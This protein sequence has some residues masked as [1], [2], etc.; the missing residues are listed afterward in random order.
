MNDMN[1]VRHCLGL[2]QDIV[3]KLG[4][5]VARAGGDSY[6]G[7]R[8]LTTPEGQN[9]L[10]RIG[11]ILADGNNP[12]I[13]MVAVERRITL[14]EAIGQCHF[15]E[16]DPRILEVFSLPESSDIVRETVAIT[17][18]CCP[19]GID[20][21]GGVEKT[22]AQ[23][24]EQGRRPATLGELLAMAETEDGCNCGATFALGSVAKTSHGDFVCYVDEEFSDWDEATHRRTPR[25]CLRMVEADHRLVE[26]ILEIGKRNEKNCSERS[27]ILA[28]RE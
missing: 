20:V 5:A 28:V 1:D 21:Y 2:T 24:K 15:D 23:L 16:V 6:R 19:Y 8:L 3:F 17:I 27:W 9:V 22:T 18:L 26:K 4:D 13:H 10:A 7:L 12:D 11:G 14:N 25:R